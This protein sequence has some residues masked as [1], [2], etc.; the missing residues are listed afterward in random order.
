MCKSKAKVGE[1]AYSPAPQQPA[2][3]APAPA[4]SAAEEAPAPAAPAAS[5]PAA[6]SASSSPFQAMNDFASG[7]MGGKS[8]D[9]KQQTEKLLDADASP[10][11]NSAASG[12]ELTGAAKRDAKID[13]EIGDAAS[14][15]FRNPDKERALAFIQTLKEQ[16]P[17]GMLMRGIRCFLKYGITPLLYIGSWYVWLFQKLYQGYQMLPTNLAQM[18][19]GACLAF[20]GGT[21]FAGIAAVEAARMFGGPDMYDHLVT[22][23]EEGGRIRDAQLKDDEEQQKTKDLT[24]EEEDDPGALVRHKTMVAMI[25]IKDPGRLQ[26]ALLALGNIYIAVIATLKFQFAKTVAVAL[27]IASQLTLPITRLA[28]PPLASITGPD[29]AHWVPAFID[30]VLKFVAVC[31]ATYIQAFISAFYSGIRGG[32]LCAEGLLHIAAER[33]I[34][35]KLPDRVIEKPFDADKSMI[36]EIIAFPIAAFGFY[37]QVSHNFQIIFPFNI[38]LLPLSLVEWFLRMQVFT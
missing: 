32:R 38:A 31:I 4:P 7:V 15:L 34:L 17:N 37:W 30:T 14:N 33:G 29:L 12:Q 19:F 6:Q 26:K 24:K 28:G 10:T 35:D 5:E 22:C 36:D 25:A 8:T 1:A 21:Y 9:K 23:F 3:P 20:F 2:A 13:K 16:P 27:G 18:V 11:A